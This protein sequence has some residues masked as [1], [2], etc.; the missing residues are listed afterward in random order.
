MKTFGDLNVGDKVY[1]LEDGSPFKV[2]VNHISGCFNF[3]V[4][5]NGALCIECNGLESL[6]CKIGDTKAETTGWEDN[7]KIKVF[8]DRDEF[9]NVLSKKIDELTDFRNNY[10]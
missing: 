5:E 10:L 2:T 6:Y 9:Y 1:C 8:T 4:Q 3:G 7:D